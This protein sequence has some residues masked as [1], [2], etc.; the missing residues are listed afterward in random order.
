MLPLRRFSPSR[1]RG[2]ARLPPNA[3]G[4]PSDHATLAPASISATP[5]RARNCGCHHLGP[6]CILYLSERSAE[7][8]VER[9]CYAFACVVL[10]LLGRRAVR[11]LVALS[12][13]GHVPFWPGSASSDLLTGGLDHIYIQMAGD[14]FGIMSKNGS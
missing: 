1:D 14:A 12:S 10:V 9:R 11:K 8:D 13:S 5:G 4:A 2:R 7:R 6:E 3:C